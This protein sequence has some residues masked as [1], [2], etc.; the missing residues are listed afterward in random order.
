VRLEKKDFTT[1]QCIMNSQLA[2]SVELTYETAQEKFRQLLAQYRHNALWFLKSDVNVD[3]TDSHADRILDL[4]ACKASR[5]NWLTI[6]KLKEWRS[7][8]FK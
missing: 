5:S 4:I 7:L 6:R 3:I 1:K 8:N 2:T